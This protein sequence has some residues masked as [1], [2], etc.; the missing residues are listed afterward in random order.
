MGPNYDSEIKEI[1]ICFWNIHGRKS[2]LIQA[3][4]LDPEFIEKL[5]NSDIVA[6]TELHTEEKDLFIPG[7]KLLKE[8]IRKK[9]HKGPKIGGGIAVFSKENIFDSAHV[10]PNTDENSIWIKL[11]KNCPDS[12]DLFIGSYYV[13]PA[14]K[15]YKVDFLKLLHEESKRFLEKGTLSFRETLM[16]EQGL[17]T[18]LSRLMLS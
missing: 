12:K 8:K 3:K 16:E 18:I 6:L 4:L 15:K 13:S 10:V 17:K 2:K 1:K 7:Y 9:I 11:K 5:E 14:N